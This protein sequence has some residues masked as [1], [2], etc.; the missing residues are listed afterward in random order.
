MLAVLVLFTTLGIASGIEQ[1]IDTHRF[2]ECIIQINVQYI[3]Q[4][5]KKRVQLNLI[6]IVDQLLIMQGKKEF[7]TK[8]RKRPRYRRGIVHGCKNMC[9]AGRAWRASEGHVPC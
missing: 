1:A 4:L 7:I 6:P 2:Y 8:T 5:P 3:D 9:V